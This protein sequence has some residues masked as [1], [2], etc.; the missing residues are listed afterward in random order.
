MDFALNE[1]KRK[2]FDAKT[3][4]ESIDDFVLSEL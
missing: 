4:L 1:K 3:L 2:E